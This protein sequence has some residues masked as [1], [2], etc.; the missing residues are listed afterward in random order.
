MSEWGVIASSVRGAS[1]VRAGTCN[2]DAEAHWF[3]GSRAVVCVADGHG[4]AAHYRSDV[5]AALAVEVG[6]SALR[7]IAAAPAET[8]DDAL[9]AAPRRIVSG[10]RTRVDAH[11]RSCPLDE[12]SENPYIAYGATLLAAGVSEDDLFFLQLG[13]GDILC[14]GQD[15]TTVRPLPP[16]ERLIANETTSLCM[17]NASDEFRFTLARGRGTAPALILVSTDGYLNSFRS[18]ADF[19]QIGP[20]YLNMLIE[21]GAAAVQEELDAILNDTSTSGSGDDITLAILYSGAAAAEPPVNRRRD[22]GRRRPPLRTLLRAICL[23]LLLLACAPI[24]RGAAREH[25]K[26]AHYATPQPW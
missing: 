23:L 4:S 10:W 1:H 7:D 25:T 9:A 6:I 22:S 21:S 24:L 16:D 12:V 20:D 5:G 26:A 15:G 17:Q 2:Q 13:D 14:V 18:D 19:L 11:I 3:E 8:R